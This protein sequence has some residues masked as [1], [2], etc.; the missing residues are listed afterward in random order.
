M[1]RKRVLFFAPF[2]EKRFQGGIMNFSQQ[3]KAFK[4]F[5]P[6]LELV[7]FNP[8][9]FDREPKGA[10]KLTF[11]NFAD[12]LILF[13]RA[14]YSVKRNKIDIIHINTSSKIPFLRDVL[15]SFIIK[16]LFREVRVFL[17]IHMTEVK[18]VIP[19][20]FTGISKYLT[21]K[22]VIVALSEQFRKDLSE[23]GFQNVAVLYNFHSFNVTAEL[24]NSSIE[25]VPDNI[26][27]L[28]FMGNI[29]P[30]KG[31][32][33][34]VTVL[35]R[36][37]LDFKFILAGAGDSKAVYYKEVMNCIEGD[38]RFFFVGYL[39]K[40]SKSDALLKSDILLLNSSSEGFPM[41]IPEALSHG[42]VV[43]STGVGAI[44]EIICNGENGYIF[45][46]IEDDFVLKLTVLSDSSKLKEMK[47][48]AFEISKSFDIESF[49]NNLADLYRYGK[50]V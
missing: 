49:V 23:V 36:T 12:A 50:Q 42:C 8:V 35:K 34:L 14:I 41:V 40:E 26:L 5:P 11:L 28:I 21:S 7:F 31:I 47:K 29:E 3:I 39:D 32:L 30:R 4:F 37:K 15:L 2:V 17:H 22:S 38:N 45:N 33:E 10:G 44:P 16:F 43:L 19:S 9:F 20:S 13:V 25:S 48:K 27:R 1:K 6:D 24:V 18:Q 46:D